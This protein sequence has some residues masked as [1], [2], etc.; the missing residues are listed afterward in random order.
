MNKKSY[1]LKNS[2]EW[3]QILVQFTRNNEPIII[4]GAPRRYFCWNF[5][6]AAMISEMKFEPTFCFTPQFLFRNE[7]L[8][9]QSNSLGCLIIDPYTGQ[10]LQKLPEVFE[11]R[12]YTKVTANGKFIVIEKHGKKKDYTLNLTIRDIFSNTEEKYQIPG[13]YRTYYVQSECHSLDDELIAVSSPNWDLLIYGRSVNEKHGKL[14]CRIP[15]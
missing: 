6:T 2:D 10:L 11:A 15:N 14:Y 8:L 5:D 9:I 13:L 7:T 3:A 1:K 4:G 12:A